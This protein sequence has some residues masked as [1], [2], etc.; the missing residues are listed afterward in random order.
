M[1]CT[2]WPCLGQGRGKDLNRVSLQGEE[3]SEK[4]A[5]VLAETWARAPVTAPQSEAKGEALD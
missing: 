1:V 2:D 4:V 5:G 3:C